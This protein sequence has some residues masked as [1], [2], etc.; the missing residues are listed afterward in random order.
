MF[1]LCYFV[2]LLSESQRRIT[3][4]DDYEYYHGTFTY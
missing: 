3:L 1:V 2:F 4:V